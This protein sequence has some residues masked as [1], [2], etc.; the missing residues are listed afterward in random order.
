M[1][2]VR[3]TA[4]LATACAVCCAI[5]VL[6]AAGIAVAPMGAAAAGIAALGTGVVALRKR[7]RRQHDAN[8]A[9][10]MVRPAEEHGR[11]AE[12]SA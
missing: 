1:K 10:G 11:G 3:E 9:G 12:A 7:H 2:G 6:A 4:V 5:P 8:V